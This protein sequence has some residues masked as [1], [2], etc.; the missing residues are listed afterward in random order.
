MYAADRGL[1]LNEVLVLAF[2]ALKNEK[3][4]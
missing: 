1:K 2:R 3:N 4:D